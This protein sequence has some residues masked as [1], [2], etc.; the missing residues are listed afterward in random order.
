[1][2]T[3]KS[4]IIWREFVHNLLW[5]FPEIHNKS[6]KRKFDNFK[7]SDNNKNFDLWAKGLTGY[8]IVDA[9][10]RELWSTGWMH[11]RVRMITASFLTK[12]LLLPWQLGEAWFWNTLVD[13]DPASNASGWQWVARMWG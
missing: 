5:Y 3:F 11:N 6:I 9:G 4:E 13:A 12:H 10:M 2:K 8:P 1:M 7:L